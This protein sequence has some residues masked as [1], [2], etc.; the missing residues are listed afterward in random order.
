MP[1]GHGPQRA[2]PSQRAAD[3]NCR[4]GRWW[5]VGRQFCDRKCV[6]SLLNFQN[7]VLMNLVQVFEQISHSFL[8][9]NYSNKKFV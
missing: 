9:S 2:G 6:F 1:A 8:Y 7:I 3:R 5:A 4:T